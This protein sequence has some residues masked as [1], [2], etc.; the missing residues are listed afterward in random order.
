M[1]RTCH[2]SKLCNEPPAFV[3]SCGGGGVLLGYNTLMEFDLFGYPFPGWS[4]A[5]DRR[6]VSEA[7][8]PLL[9]KLFPA[10][11]WALQ[12]EMQQLTREER[13]LLLEREQLTS[14][15]A[16]RGDGVHVLINRRQDTYAFI[17]DEEHLMVQTYHPGGMAELKGAR[18]AALKDQKRF[19]KRLPVAFDRKIGMLFSDPYKGGEGIWIAALVHIPGIMLSYPD[20]NLS[21]SM[22]EMGIL[23]LPVLSRSKNEKGNM[24]W[25][26]SPT[27]QELRDDAN[28]DTFLSTVQELCR[29]EE[30]AR[31]DML[32]SLS[33]RKFL[34]QSIDCAVAKLEKSRSLSYN[35]LLH[36]LSVLRLGLALGECTT[37][38]PEEE[39]SEL[40]VRAYTEALPTYLEVAHKGQTCRKRR[41]L[42][43][44]LM[45]TLIGE[46]LR[47][48][49]P[50]IENC[51]E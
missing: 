29:R 42:R 7:I 32:N 9:D 31:H 2:P 23:C 3:R 10:D 47:I 15:M 13:M 35:D 46:Q 8:L 44:S 51:H 41:S 28:Y 22:S 39:R 6:A 1:T 49:I 5:R 18:T 40:I 17:N 26:C 12:A 16:A 21:D 25:L 19:F 20:H 45:R 4:E 43:A 30:Q 33:S 27:A 24:Y 14:T 36:A 38:I 48:R 37:D 11:E 34:R 50:S